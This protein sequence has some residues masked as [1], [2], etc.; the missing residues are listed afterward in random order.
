MSLLSRIHEYDRAGRLV[1]TVTDLVVVEVVTRDGNP[2]DALSESGISY[3][4]NGKL[5]SSC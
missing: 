1:E 3:D 4:S 5:L 2:V